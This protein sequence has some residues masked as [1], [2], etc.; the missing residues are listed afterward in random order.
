MKK[1]LGEI[2]VDKGLITAR[3]LDRVLERSRALGQK[4]GFTLEDIGL[5]TGEELAE[6]LAEQYGY[7]IVRDFARYNF[8]KEV[9]DIVSCDVAMQY[10]I[11]PLQRKSSVLAVAVADP[12]DSKIT[13]NIA[14]NHKL[15][16]RHFIATRQEI[17]TAINRNYLGK[18]AAASETPTILV[19]ED[20]KLI[21]SML[22]NLLSKEG[23]RVLVETDGMEAYKTALRELPHV[24]VT[25]K[26]MPRLDGY[27]LLDS[28]KTIPETSS[29]P[30]ILLTGRN[31]EEE[32]AR[33]FAKGF[34]D[35][36]PKPVRDAAL[37]ARIRRAYRAN[38]DAPPL[39]A[40]D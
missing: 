9:L 11:F 12:T 31:T 34:F 33:A 13:D 15:E 28:L 38:G 39:P 6:A 29:I 20:S 26:E 16:I 2:L 37:V 3:T 7:K 17:V 24:I 23:Y 22:R 1:R 18:T 14:S 19:V 10:L 35:F 32:E 36:V 4:L 27:A 8:P 5:V 40:G 21:S 30:M 25:D